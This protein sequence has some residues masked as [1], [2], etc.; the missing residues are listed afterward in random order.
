MEAQRQYGIGFNFVPWGEVI[1]Q[2]ATNI[3]IVKKN[4]VI[5]YIKKKT[6]INCL[7]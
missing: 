2:G 3:I 1:E 6:F 5:C 4:S 7:K